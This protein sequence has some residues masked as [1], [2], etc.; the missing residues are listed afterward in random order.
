MEAVKVLDAKGLAC[1]MP[2]VRTKKAIEEI[3]SGEILE[4]HTTDQGS[5][6]DLTAWAKSGGH[7]LVKEA[8]EGD[9]FKFWIKKA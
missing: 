4:V 7:E 8:E 3:N 5:K 6:S 2:V 1:P 9:V